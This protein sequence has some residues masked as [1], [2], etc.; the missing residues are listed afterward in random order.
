LHLDLDR[1]LCRHV[2]LNQVHADRTG[3]KEDDPGDENRRD[4]LVDLHRVHSGYAPHPGFSD[5]P[6]ISWNRGVA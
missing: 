3:E 1:R 5:A 4:D 6:G 2:V